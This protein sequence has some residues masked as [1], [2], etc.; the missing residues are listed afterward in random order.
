MIPYFILGEE[1][2]MAAGPGI[3]ITVLC[4]AAYAIYV[5]VRHKK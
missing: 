3:T 1:T 4:I 2:V 5:N